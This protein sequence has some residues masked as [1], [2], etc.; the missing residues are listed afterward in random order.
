M[1]I[2]EL[3]KN[4]IKNYIKILGLA[5][6][7]FGTAQAMDYEIKVTQNHKPNAEYF[8]ISIGEVIS[9]VLIFDVASSLV[10]ICRTKKGF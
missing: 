10:C 2:C 8:R 5:A 9:T 6:V 7:P 1:K 3:M 4:H